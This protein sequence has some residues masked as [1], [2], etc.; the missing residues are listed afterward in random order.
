MLT[1]HENENLRGVI[2]Y[3]V[4][5]EHSHMLTSFKKFNEAVDKSREESFIT[6]FPEFAEWY[7]NI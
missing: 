2:S 5:N 3:M 7:R 4:K 1:N 6:I